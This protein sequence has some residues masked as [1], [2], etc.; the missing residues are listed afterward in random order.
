MSAIKARVL[1]RSSY[2]LGIYYALPLLRNFVDNKP[3][4]THIDLATTSNH[5][6]VVRGGLEVAIMLSIP[7]LDLATT[8]NYKGVLVGG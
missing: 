6:G 5:N 2:L 3:L 4:T 7:A 8:S 1:I